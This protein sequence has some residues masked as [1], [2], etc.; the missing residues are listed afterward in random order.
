MLE[1]SR[2]LRSRTKNARN[3][4]PEMKRLGGDVENDLRIYSLRGRARWK[5]SVGRYVSRLLQCRQF[6]E[7][8]L[9]EVPLGAAPSHSQ[10]VLHSVPKPPGS[11]PGK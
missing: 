10:F 9:R 3:R 5:A 11:L 6:S 8:G 4:D 7:L 1:D 2:S